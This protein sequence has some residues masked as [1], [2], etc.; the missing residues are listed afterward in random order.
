MARIAT[1]ACWEFIY[2][3]AGQE[4]LAAKTE[5]DRLKASGVPEI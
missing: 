3:L 5:G 1:S 2:F 4:C